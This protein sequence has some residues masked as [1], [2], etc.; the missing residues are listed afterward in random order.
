MSLSKNHIKRLKKYKLKKFRDADGIFIV[1]K[2]K[3]IDI[4]LKAGYKPVEL[5][6]SV[7]PSTDIP[8]NEI[9]PKTLKE[10]SLLKNPYDAYAVFRKPRPPVFDP[11]QTTIFLYR[12]QDPGNLGTVI[13]SAAWFGVEQIVC[14]PGSTDF[15]HPKT[16]QSA[17]GAWVNVRLFQMPF[18]ELIRKTSLPVWAA[19]MNGENMF[20]TDFP[21]KFVLVM[22]NEG[23]GIPVN[24]KEKSGKIIS[25]PGSQKF[26]TESLN[27]SIATGIIIA[28]WF[29]NKSK[30]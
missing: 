18:E 6:A 15:Y 11:A 5:Y 4:F 8:Y 12:I 19:D 7:P 20:E 10:I 23:S 22:G 29:R 28:E 30:Q 26:S 9:S 25:I 24:I 21:E 13:R 27:V 17:A 14:S 2:W 1:E 3:N 16:L